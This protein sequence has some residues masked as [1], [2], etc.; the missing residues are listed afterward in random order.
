[1]GVSLILI[2]DDSLSLGPWWPFMNEGLLQFLQGTDPTGL[3]IGLQRFDEVCEADAYLTPLVPLAPLADNLPALMNALPFPGVAST[4]TIPALDGVIRYA[5]EQA[6]RSA[7]TRI[8][9]VL[10]T[11]ASP[12]ACDGLAGDYEGEAQRIAR[13]GY[14]G[15][16]SIKTYV[17]GFSTLPTPGL[18]A[19]A[20]GTEPR[21]ISVTPGDSDVRNALESIRRDAQPC[22]FK[23]PN[24]WTL[25]PESVVRVT[26]SN[27]TDRTYPILS[28]SAM[29]DQQ[30]GFYV[31]A[32]TAGYPV[33]A[34]PQ[35]CAALASNSRLTVSNVC[36]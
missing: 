20:G 11:D 6:M 26:A 27:G 7:D 25:A 15:T 28:N 30:E 18:I 36:K 16:P 33:L 21:L 17:V 32:A 29:C 13:E 2:V 3:G 19:P 14:Q 34:C 10:V 24:G 5:R 23:A 1:M 9:V 35:T 12:G 4:S 31:E 22:A 8:S